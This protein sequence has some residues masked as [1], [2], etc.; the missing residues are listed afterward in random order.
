M[1]FLLEKDAKK[2]WRVYVEYWLPALPLLTWDK[3][4]A[5]FLYNYMP[6]ALCDCK[7]D[8]FLALEQGDISVVAYEAKFHALSRYAT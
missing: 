3:F 4:H 7:K 2:C 5:L 8:Q 6:Q 1:N